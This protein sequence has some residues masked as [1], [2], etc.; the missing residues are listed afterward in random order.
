MK[1]ERG[2]GFVSPWEGVEYYKNSL[3]GAGMELR[4]GGCHVKDH[5][6][7]GCEMDCRGQSGKQGHRLICY[8]IWAK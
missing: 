5:S 8:G 1:L 4:A 6:G 3:N 2:E 7:A